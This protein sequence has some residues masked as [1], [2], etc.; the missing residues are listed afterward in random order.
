M[1]LDIGLPLDQLHKPLRAAL[2]G[3]RSEVEVPAVNRR[4]KQIT[5][6]IVVTPLLAP[7]GEPRGAILLM[8][9]R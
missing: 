4:G 5:C 2:A 1:N 8:E 7:T 6:G 9:A 3:A